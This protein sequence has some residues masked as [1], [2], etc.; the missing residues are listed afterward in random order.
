M[1]ERIFRDIFDSIGF[2]GVV[3]ICMVFMVFIVCVIDVIDVDLFCGCDVW[4]FC[5][6]YGCECMFWNED[7]FRVIE[8]GVC[9]F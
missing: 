1:I 9:V 3:L 7:C 2:V 4:W 8:F 6:E 5:C